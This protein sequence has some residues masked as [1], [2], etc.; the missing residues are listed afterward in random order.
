MHSENRTLSFSK[1]AFGFS[2]PVHS[3]SLHISYLIMRY[4]LTF[5]TI[6]AL[7]T[8]Q[9]IDALPPCSLSCFATHVPETGC[10]LTDFA[11]SCSKSSELTPKLTPCVQAACALEDQG[12]VVAALEKICNEAG[13]PIAIPTTTHRVESEPVTSTYVAPTSTEEPKESEGPEA[14]EQT[15]AGMCV[16]LCLHF[17]RRSNLNS[18]LANH[19]IFRYL[20]WLRLSIRGA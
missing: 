8:A 13:V 3:F 11:C 9:S 2:P 19:N 5:I 12:K 17:V 7:A 6:V 14:P 1:V 16:L 15:S 18:S 4:T 10:G 20:Q